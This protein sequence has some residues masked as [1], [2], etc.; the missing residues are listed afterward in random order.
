MNQNIKNGLGVVAALVVLMLGYSAISYVNSY[1]KSIQPSSFRSFSVS[2]EGK[3]T[4]IPDV[5]KFTFTVITEGGKDVAAL[6]KDNTDKTNKAIAFVKSSGVEEKDIKTQSYNIDPRYES[7]KCRSAI[8]SISPV[9]DYSAGAVCPPA[10]IV[11]YTVTQTVEVKVRDFS[12]TGDIMAGIVKNGA[13]QV[14]SLSFTIDDSTKVQADARAQAITKAREKAESIAKAGG[15]GIGQ[16]LSIQEGGYYPAYAKAAYDSSGYGIGGGVA[17][18][19]APTIQ[20]GSQ[21]VNITVTLQY[22]IR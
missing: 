2:G 18:N 9:S 8:S 13:N 11:G 22:E 16:L 3:V 14:S 4:A 10:S 6:Q 5:A 17:Q 1:G 7:Y 20:P 19:A 15:F 12:K 21:E